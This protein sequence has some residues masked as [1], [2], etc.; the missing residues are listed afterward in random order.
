MAPDHSHNLHHSQTI[1]MRVEIAPASE[2]DSESLRNRF[3][4]IAKYCP[5]P[6]QGVKFF[7]FKRALRMNWH[8]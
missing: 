7:P 4:L 1:I 6:T 5:D 3:A 2:P 8:Q